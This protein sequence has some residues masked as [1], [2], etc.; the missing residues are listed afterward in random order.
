[1][2]HRKILSLSAFAV[3][4]IMAFAGS[5]SATVIKKDGVNMTAGEAISASVSSSWLLKTG[6]GT[7]IATCTEGSTGGS[8]SNAGGA[9]L[10]VHI[11]ITITTVSKCN[12]TVDTLANGTWELHYRPL[13][14]LSITSTGAKT[15]VNFLGVSCVFETKSTEVGTLTG[16]KPAT[17]DASGTIPG[18]S[19]FPCPSSAILSGG[20][21]VTSPGGSTL[22]G[23]ES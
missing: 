20:Y 23:A 18:I 15:T 5:A 4:A 1:M 14:H 2:K 17:V 7:T 12:T 16:G 10:T 21:T 11:S 8:L 9:S 22:D 19:G 3:M 6:G 13:F